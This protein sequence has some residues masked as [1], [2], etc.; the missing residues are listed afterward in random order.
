MIVKDRRIVQDD[1]ELEVVYS[2]TLH[3]MD[4]V[5]KFLDSTGGAFQLSEFTYSGVA[6][7]A[8]RAFTRSSEN[9]FST[10]KTLLARDIFSHNCII[11]QPQAPK[12]DKES[13]RCED[14][15]D[16]TDF[17]YVELKLDVSDT[18]FRVKDDDIKLAID[19]YLNDNHE[20]R[21][22]DGQR[23]DDECTRITKALNVDLIPKDRNLALLRFLQRMEYDP[24]AE[25]DIACWVLHKHSLESLI[26]DGYS[27]L[28][29]G[30]CAHNRPE[31]RRPCKL[32]V[33]FTKGWRRASDY[34]QRTFSW[35]VESGNAPSPHEGD[36]N[37]EKFSEEYML[38]RTFGGFKKGRDSWVGA[39]VIHDKRA[40]HDCRFPAE[41]EVFV[42]GG[43][44]SNLYV[45]YSQ[46][47]RVGRDDV[48]V[49]IKE[50]RGCKDK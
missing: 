11:L 23:L 30:E 45:A 17:P 44:V 41:I 8:L 4:T 42:D 22:R 29:V 32:V 47:A 5:N 38:H 15:D 18:L 21:M 9:Q 24:Y 14:V 43:G 28:A 2:A 40:G 16:K 13:L 46:G 39:G 34:S 6:S 25:G 50:G 1:V 49:S 7:Q 37:L 31:S 48:G 20:E 26:D 3:S 35:T 36:S 10:T 27:M 33:E 12:Q 19:D